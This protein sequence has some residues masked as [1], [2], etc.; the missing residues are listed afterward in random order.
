MSGGALAEVG[1]FAATIER[2]DVRRFAAAI[3]YDGM[4]GPLAPPTYPMRL[5]A[6]SAAADHLRTLAET[7]GG[8]PIHVSQAFDY[9]RR[10]RIGEDIHGRILSGVEGEGARQLAVLVL[11]LSDAAGRGVARCESRFAIARTQAA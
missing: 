5:L 10:L 1:R 8:M 6:A 9:R 2:D 3:G 11:E 7:E 4:V